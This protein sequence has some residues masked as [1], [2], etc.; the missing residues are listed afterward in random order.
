MNTNNDVVK[1]ESMI[2]QRDAKQEAALAFGKPIGFLLLHA[3]CAMGR[4]LALAGQETRKGNARMR[5]FGY[6]GRYILQP[7]SALSRAYGSGLGRLI[8]GL[9]SRDLYLGSFFCTY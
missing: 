8:A 6:S 5:G 3:V 4:N 2:Y 9:R 1:R 7:V